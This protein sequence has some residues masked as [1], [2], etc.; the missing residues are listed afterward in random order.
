[1]AAARSREPC[2][3]ALPESKGPAL[4]QEQHSVFGQTLTLLKRA[5]RFA[6]FPY[7]TMLGAESCSCDQ[8]DDNW[9]H[10]SKLGVSLLDTLQHAHLGSAA[11]IQSSVHIHGNGML[12]PSHTHVA[13]QVL[14]GV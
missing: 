4:P 8:L 14:Q 13:T 1:M 2:P 10:C 7:Q 12:N 11:S 9:M 3:K 5:G 6:G